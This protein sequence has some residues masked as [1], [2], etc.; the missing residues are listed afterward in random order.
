MVLCLADRVCEAGPLSD[1][2]CLKPPVR[3]APLSG[4]G[5]RLPQRPPRL[6][7]PR[8]G[9]CHLKLGPWP[10]LD[11]PSAGSPVRTAYP[12]SRSSCP[13]LVTAPCHNIAFHQ[14]TALFGASAATSTERRMSNRHR[15]WHFLSRPAPSGFPPSVPEMGPPRIGHLANLAI[16][17]V[18]NLAALALFRS[19]CGS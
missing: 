16:S 4:G 6:P 13:T 15:S 12:L 7:S 19:I 14:A 3:S 9:L 1:P 2:L 11:A 17:R 5:A 10:W 18:A 8:H